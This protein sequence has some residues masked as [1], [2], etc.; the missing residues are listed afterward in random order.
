MQV[1]LHLMPALK[2]DPAIARNR[3]QDLTWLPKRFIWNR[4]IRSAWSA[5][6]IIVAAV[7]AAL[8][9]L[10]STGCQFFRHEELDCT[11][12]VTYGPIKVEDRVIL[13]VYHREVKISGQAGE[14]STF[15]A[16]LPYKI[17]SESEN[18]LDFEYTTTTKCG[19][20]STRTGRLNKVLGTLRLSRSDREPIVGEYMC[21][22]A[23]RVLR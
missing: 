18:E 3:A 14:T 10:L 17:C 1:E 20:N 19:H 9:V 21:K 11:G 13:K 7:V 23:Q 2:I 16:E 6:T 5:R 12:S 8:V 15:E 22:P 4:L